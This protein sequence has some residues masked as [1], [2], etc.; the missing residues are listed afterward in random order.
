VS[1]GIDMEEVGRRFEEVKGV[2]KTIATSLGEALVE[3]PQYDEVSLEF[4]VK[5]GGKAG[6]P[7]VT[8]GSAEANFKISIKWKSLSR[9]SPR[10]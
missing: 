6:I 5:V 7:F 3:V 9:T 4:G 2:V 8:E 1:G 10:G